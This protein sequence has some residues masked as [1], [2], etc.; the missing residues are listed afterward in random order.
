MEINILESSEYSIKFILRNASSEFANAIRRIAISEVPSM[1]IDD[2]FFYE[3]TSVLN[4][5]IIAHRLGLIPLKTDLKSYQLPEKCKCKSEIG[6]SRCRVTG[7]LDVEAEGVKRTVYSGDLK[8][9]DPDIVPVSDRIPIVKIDGDQK[10]KLEVHAKLGTGRQHAKW[11][12]VPTCIYKNIP[13]INI[14]HK[15]CDV[16]KKCVDVC[17]KHILQLSKN[18]IIV[19]DSNKCTFCMECV[20]ACPPNCHAIEVKPDSTSFIFTIET[21]KSISAKTVLLEAIEVLREK[22]DEMEEEIRGLK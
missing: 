14:N 9:E 6:C 16:C 10:I 8:F 5:E 1:T 17:P 11:E 18:Q 7:T 12:A 21:N 20:K 22:A 4:D 13:I 15:K 3:N 19:T 2:V